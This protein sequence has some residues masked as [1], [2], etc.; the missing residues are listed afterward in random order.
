VGLGEALLSER[1][2]EL[3]G[4]AD[5]DVRLR[6][7]LLGRDPGLEVTGCRKREDVRVDAGRGLERAEEL[8]V[9]RVVQRRVHLDRAARLRR[10][11][12]RCVTRGRRDATGTATRADEGRRTGERQRAT[13]LDV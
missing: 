4:T 11:G 10:R 12:R 5:E 7:V 6:V 1:V 2:V 8:V 3:A 9:R 13:A